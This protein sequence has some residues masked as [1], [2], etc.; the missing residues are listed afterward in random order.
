MFTGFQEPMEARKWLSNIL[1]LELKVIVSHLTFVLRTELWYSERT[2]QELLELLSH[3]S[4]PL[5]DF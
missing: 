4:S 2:V 1:V 5:T 3:L